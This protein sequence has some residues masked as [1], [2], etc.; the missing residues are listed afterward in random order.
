MFLECLDSMINQAIKVPLDAPGY[1]YAWPSVIL[2]LDLA[3][4]VK[5]PVFTAV[6]PNQFLIHHC[7]KHNATQWYFVFVTTL[8]KIMLSP[9]F[10]DA[11]SSLLLLCPSLSP[12]LPLFTSFFLHVSTLP[13]LLLYVRIL[14]VYLMN[15]E[16]LCSTLHVKY[17]AFQYRWALW[18]WYYVWNEGPYSVR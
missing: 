4:L 8:Y 18:F 9:C 1:V 14:W 7:S 10:L 13:P 5:G 3:H 17:I 11:M 16:L 2:L 15:S 6:S 12:P